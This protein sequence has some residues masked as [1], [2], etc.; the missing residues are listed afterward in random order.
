MSASACGPVRSRLAGGRWQFQ[1]GP[2][3]LILDAEGDV[4]ACE[5]AYALC[6]HRFQTVLT[7]L[8]GEL[9]Q[10]RRPAGELLEYGASAV[11]GP[12]AGRMVGACVPFA[13]ERFVTPMAAV[14]GAVAEE[15][16]EFFRRPGIHRAY[17]NNGGDIALHL[18]AGASYRVGIWSNLERHPRRE[19]TGSELDGDFA[20]EAAMPIRG[21]ATSGWRGR[22]L[23]LGIADSV[24][25]LADG[26]A[27]ADVAATL[28]ANAVN[29]DVAGII[30]VPAERLKDDT[31]LGGLA[32]T[33]AV[34]S[35]PP[36]AVA[37]ALQAGRREA[38][39][40]RERGRLYAAVLL[41]QG[42]AAT[43]LPREGRAAAHASLQLRSACLPEVA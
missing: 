1:H 20:V 15:L 34:P 6:W 29:C 7:E 5:Q 39:Y 43:V 32:V 37:Q 27:A 30:R 18:A 2:I 41:L 25:V 16:I 35:L 23:S 21:V 24:T 13:P 19:A 28:V 11:S 10:L 12:I 40:W 22:S 42:R 36:E 8:V 17:I 4:H 33:V 26:A 31:D 38:E 14:A 9:R 3:T